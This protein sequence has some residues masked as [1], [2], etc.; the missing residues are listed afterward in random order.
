MVSRAI[1]PWRVLDPIHLT[2]AKARSLQ[3]P[4]V[5]VFSLLPL[6]RACM[7]SYIARHPALLMIFFSMLA[8]ACSERQVDDAMLTAK[9]K[10]RMTTDGRVSPTRVDVDT[11][12][13]NVTLS[14]ET[15]TQEEKSAA[16]EIARNVEGV[17]SVS[18]QIQ[19]NPAVAGTGIPSGQEMKRQAEKAVS[20]VG[21][22]V[23]KEAENAF[24]LGEVKAR[25]A[26]AGFGSVGVG[27]DHGVVTLKGETSNEKDRIAA[28]AIVEKV[29][30]V[31]KVDNQMILK[32]PS[33]S[34]STT[35][36]PGH[37]PSPR[38]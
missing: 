1:A 13:G 32:K 2:P 15:P 34:P 16:E 21:Q 14:G 25:L 10:T 35:V 24:L 5:V 36:C 11:L 12:N 7:K 26:A 20:D 9:I 30:G 28:E 31:Q 37:S 22:G 38:R 8:A 4:P 33:P 17:R 18:N 3:A 19:V 23:K 6:E 27:V 29:K